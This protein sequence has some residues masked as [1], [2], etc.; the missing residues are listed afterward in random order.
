MA[1][2]RDQRATHISDAW[3]SSPS[4]EGLLRAASQVA[5]K[6]AIRLVK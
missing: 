2:L 5:F 4:A 3:R 6:S 1:L